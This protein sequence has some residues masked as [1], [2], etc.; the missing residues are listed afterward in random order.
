MKLL[1]ITTLISLGSFRVHRPGHGLVNYGKSAAR[2]GGP[3]DSNKQRKL[4]DFRES[5]L[6]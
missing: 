1:L 2:T 5:G 3:C 4:V 6:F